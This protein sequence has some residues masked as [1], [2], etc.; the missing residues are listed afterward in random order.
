MRS[1][2]SNVVVMTPAKANDH[3]EQPFFRPG[4]A[5]L[6]SGIYRVYH[7]GHRLPHEV[8]LLRN[9]RFPPCIKCGNSISFD[10]A[11]SIPAL[12]DL[13]F[14]IHLYSIPHPEPDAA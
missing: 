12:E 10:L 5:I 3:P 9:E 2:R 4:D 1:R 11:R 6:E 7:A 14:H 13:D 8:T